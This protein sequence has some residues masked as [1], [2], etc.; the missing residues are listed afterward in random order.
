MAVVQAIVKLSSLF[1]MYNPAFLISRLVITAMLFLMNHI[2]SDRFVVSS[3]FL[4]GS[5]CLLK[6]RSVV[7]V[8][9]RSL[10]RNDRVEG[11]ITYSGPI[12]VRTTTYAATTPIKIPCTCVTVS[13]A[14]TPETE[15]LHVQ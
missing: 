6:V 13:V 12:I 2:I 7:P 14:K 5:L 10:E 11:T 3:P 4:K 8:Q 9:P 15:G 1:L